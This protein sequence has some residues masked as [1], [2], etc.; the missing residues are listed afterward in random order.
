[1]TGLFIISVKEIEIEPVAENRRELEKQ[2]ERK[3]I[4]KL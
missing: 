4:N 3:T 1:M 2:P